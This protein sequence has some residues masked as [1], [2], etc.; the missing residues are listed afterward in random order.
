MKLRLGKPRRLA[1]IIPVR[2]PDWA[3]APE[4]GDYEDRRMADPAGCVIL[5]VILPKA[6][7]I[8]NGS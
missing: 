8:W 2:Q 4:D 6:L 3:G 5:L 7:L 1:F